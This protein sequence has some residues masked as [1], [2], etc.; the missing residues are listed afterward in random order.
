MRAVLLWCQLYHHWRLL[1]SCYNCIQLS[2]G[3]KHIPSLLALKINLVVQQ[4]NWA[5]NSCFPLLEL[6]YTKTNGW[7][8]T[9]IEGEGHF[10]STYIIK[11]YYKARALGPWNPWIYKGSKQI[12]KGSSIEI[13]ILEFWVHLGP[14]GLQIKFYKGPIEFSGTCGL[15]LWVPESPKCSSN[16]TWFCMTQ[17]WLRLNINHHGQAMR[18]LLWGFGREL[19]TL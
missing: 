9:W 8:D 5:L 12:L 3:T 18:C 2:H 11:W 14:L 17:S 13:H 6:L 1:Q 4:A 10:Y 19:T 7:T 16:M 15:E